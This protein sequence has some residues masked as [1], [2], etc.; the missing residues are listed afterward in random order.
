M[1]RTSFV[2]LP[3]TAELD[4]F[5]V[6]AK[7]LMDRRTGA[8]LF[9]LLDLRRA[10]T[11]PLE[12]IKRHAAFV[13]D[14]ELLIRAALTGI[15]FVARSPMVRGALKALFWMQ[16]PPTRVSVDRDLDEAM[17]TLASLLAE[18]R[19]D[20]AVAPFE[21]DPATSGELIRP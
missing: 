2:G 5:F 4:A 6:W 14:Q 13:A 19:V 7:E 20:R 8:P 21:D 17:T 10:P 9:V 3:T 15:V 11:P 18:V 16:A 1:V 12:H